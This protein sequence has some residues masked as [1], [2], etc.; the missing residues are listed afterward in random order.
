MNGRL[1]LRMCSPLH[2]F[3][4]TSFAHNRPLVRAVN[5]AGLSAKIFGRKKRGAEQAVGSFMFRVFP[6]PFSFCPPIFFAKPIPDPCSLR[7][8]SFSKNIWPQ[9]K[10]GQSKQSAVLC[11]ACSL[12][13][14]LFAHPSFCQNRFLVRAVSGAG[15]SAKTFWPQ[16]KG[17]VGRHSSLR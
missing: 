17:G 9:K 15:L 3:A 4:H 6:A 16:K 12:R 7:R 8:R 13:R 2:L 11:F 10:G 14:S 1:I 5:G